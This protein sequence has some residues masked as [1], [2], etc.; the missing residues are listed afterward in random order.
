M[1]T[2]YLLVVAAELLNNSLACKHHQITRHV[3]DIYLISRVGLLFFV[4]SC[5]RASFSSFS[6]CLLCA[7]SCFHVR[8]GKVLMRKRREKKN[9]TEI[10]YSGRTPCAPSEYTGS[11]ELQRLFSFSA[12]QVRGSNALI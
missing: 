10:F 3:L 7:L 4:F 1:P 5:A 2:F 11:L 8:V 9:T 6:F 12:Q